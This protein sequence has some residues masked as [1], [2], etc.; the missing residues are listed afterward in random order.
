MGKKEHAVVEKKFCHTSI[1]RPGLLS[2]DETSRLTERLA[3]K[4]LP[5]LPVRKLARAMVL[6][7]ENVPRQST[8]IEP[9]LY[10]IG[11]DVIL[12]Q[13]VFL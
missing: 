6:D 11:N 2:R 12:Q 5:S 10:Y 1:F 9:P 8:T 7:A 4:M 13:L 3:T